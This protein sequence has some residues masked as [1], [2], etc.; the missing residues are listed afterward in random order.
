MV[1]LSVP[2]ES[3]RQFMLT[4][5]DMGLV[6]SGEWVFMD[7]EL[8][9]FA[10][11]YWGDH[12]WRKGDANDT[13]AREAY[14]SLLRI[15]LIEPTGS[16]FEN[17]SDEV[18]QRAKDNHNFDYT[19]RNEKVIVMQLNNYCEI[20]FII[21]LYRIY[22]YIYITIQGYPYR[23]MEHINPNSYLTYDDRRKVY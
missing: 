4:A 17:F 16:Q 21:Y 13:R 15:A 23:Y 22:I 8:F 19:A 2:G 11:G 14:E 10:G 3:V 6:Q 1:V 7:V 5:W 20:N 18:K 9:P 12:G